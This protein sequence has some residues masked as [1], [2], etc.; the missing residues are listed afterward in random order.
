MKPYVFTEEDVECL[1]SMGHQESE[2]EQLQE[3]CNE[4]MMTLTN[5]YGL[6]PIKAKQ[7]I[8]VLGREKF[9][10]GVSEVSKKTECARASD[11]H[12]GLGVHFVCFY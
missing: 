4:T 10:S 6:Q 7:A 1:L 3:V 12:P 8:R 5:G 9:L 11:I 2:M